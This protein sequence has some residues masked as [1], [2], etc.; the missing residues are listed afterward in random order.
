M[1]LSG[2]DLDSVTRTIL[3]E[4]GTNAT[5]ASMAAVA[6]VVRSRLAAGGYGKSPSEIVHAPGQFEAWTPPPGGEGPERCSTRKAR[7]TDKQMNEIGADAWCKKIASEYGP[8]L[9]GAVL[10]DGHR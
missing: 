3:G 2:G 5:P 9:P 7:L 8:H 6:S 4:A 1:D 10:F